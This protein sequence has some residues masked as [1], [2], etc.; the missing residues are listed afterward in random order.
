MKALICLL[1]LSI[2]SV[3]AEE[4]EVDMHKLSKSLGHM[5][6]KQLETTGVEI[7]IKEVVKGIEEA[8]AGKTAPLSYETCVKQLMLIQKKVFDEQ[9]ALNLQKANTFLEENA[10]KKNIK[11]LIAQKLQYEI[12]V[13]GKGKPVQEIY[14]PLVSFTGKTLSN[15]TFSSQDKGEVLRF[16]DI[17][18]GLKHGII[19]MKEGEKRKLYIHPDLAY[20]KNSRDF[21]NELIIFEIE[22]LKADAPT[23]TSKELAQERAYR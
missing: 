21:P 7:D 3:F 19:G 22:I 5:I 11:E 10:K 17:I 9:S 23:S 2:F 6:S 4:Q 20:G 13:Q 16:H 8:K 1:C 14:S 15:K 12:L 18:E